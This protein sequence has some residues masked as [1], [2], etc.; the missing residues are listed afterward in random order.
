MPVTIVEGDI[1]DCAASVLVNPVTSEGIE[2]NEL[3]GEFRKR[4]PANHSFYQHACEMGELDPG[5]FLLYEV[6]GGRQ[7]KHILNASTRSTDEGHSSLAC[8]QSLVANIR[9][10]VNA[11]NPTVVALPALGAGVDG[12]LPW[13]VVRDMIV[14]GLKEESTQFLLYKP[15]HLLVTDTSACLS[16]ISTQWPARCMSDKYPERV[17]SVDLIGH[18]REVRAK[19]QVAEYTRKLG[20]YHPS[21]ISK[22][23]VCYR[24][25]AYERLGL[26]PVRKRVGHKM[27]SWFEMG[28]LLHDLVQTEVMSMRG[29]FGQTFESEV[30]INFKPLNIYGHCDGVFGDWVVELKGMGKTSFAK[31]R[32]PLKE[33]IRQV[34]CY[35]IALDIPQTVFVYLCRDDGDMK[36]F[37]VRFDFEVFRPLVDRIAHVE[38]FLK[39]DEL[40]PRDA[41]DYLCAACKYEYECKRA[42]KT[43]VLT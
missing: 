22:S 29:Q 7:V 42:S 28:N 3:C 33:H 43:K 13:I 24:A 36:E 25:L 38:S 31:L 16:P 9:R 10:Y 40:P 11:Y 5:G 20:C 2:V 39:R 15:T 34:H 32:K 14:N 12:G 21:S 1:F 37:R 19:K 30:E 8:V 18:I 17:H 23:K 35:M 4:Y 26:P 27:S 6:P 41:P